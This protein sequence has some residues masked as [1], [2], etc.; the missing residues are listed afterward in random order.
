MYKL[1][2]Q[3]PVNGSSNYNCS[4]V[5]K[6]LVV[7]ELYKGWLITDGNRDLLCKGISQLDCET[8]ESSRY[9]S[10]S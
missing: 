8:H 1:F 3:A 5:A 6:F 10:R 7:T 2:L 4:M 9:E